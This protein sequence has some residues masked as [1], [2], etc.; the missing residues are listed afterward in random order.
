M[1]KI[2]YIWDYWLNRLPEP[3]ERPM[4]KIIP[5]PGKAPEPFTEK[6][7]EPFMERLQ[8]EDFILLGYRRL[9]PGLR[10][11]S[12]LAY[13]LP[14]TGPRV[15]KACFIDE[16]KETGEIELMSWGRIWGRFLPDEREYT[17]TDAV[18]LVP[19][20]PDRRQEYL[21]KHR[22]EEEKNE[23]RIAEPM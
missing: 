16:D 15:I 3:A 11:R 13:Y 1:G 6:A 5:F 21:E 9:H 8:T 7:L 17:Y 22:A 18:H 10:V 4:A 23:R 12:Y 19:P 2:F 20:N 14:K